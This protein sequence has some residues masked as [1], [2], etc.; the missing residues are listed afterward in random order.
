MPR[1]K[2]T[3]SFN[4]LLEPSLMKHIEK[5]SAKKHIPKAQL[6]RDWCR[7]AIE[8][9]DIAERENKTTGDQKHGNTR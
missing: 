3:A 4:M 8:E 6:I 2:L 7:N 9:L 5:I 1:E